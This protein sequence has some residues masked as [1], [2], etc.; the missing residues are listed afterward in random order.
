MTQPA[1]MGDF[2]LSQLDAQALSR[3]RHSELQRT[4]VAM[5]RLAASMGGYET[6]YADRGRRLARAEAA[7]VHRE[8]EVATLKAEVATLSKS[9]HLSKTS[10]RHRAGIEAAG[11]TN[12]ALVST[13]YR[14]SLGEFSAQLKHAR[15]RLHTERT[16]AELRER[17]FE[18]ELKA[19]AA[20][21]AKLQLT[22]RNL[23][24]LRE[25][26]EDTQRKQVEAAR[27]EQKAAQESA[28]EARSQV[29]ALRRRA[30]AAEAAAAKFERDVAERTARVEK[31]A[32]IL[33]DERERYAALKAEMSRAV[34]SFDARLRDSTSSFVETLREEREWRA[35][36][37]SGLGRLNSVVENKVGWL[38]VMSVLVSPPLAKTRTGR[39][40]EAA[41]S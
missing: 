10:E 16:F 29:E 3:L 17:K 19:R 5:A 6:A 31:T 18:V 30:V 12:A 26:E 13:Q 15:A 4:H 36:A 27:A 34:E 21:I 28:S 24:E 9:I 1:T 8:E 35:K 33:H 14:S 32:A 41:L 23:T 11:K 25:L 20:R 22:V 37:L 7:L 38:D 2:H 39:A 40:V